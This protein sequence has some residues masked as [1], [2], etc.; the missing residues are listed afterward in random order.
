[1]VSHISTKPNDNSS[2]T[3]LVPVD[4]IMDKKI[5]SVHQ[6]TSQ[7]YEWLPWIYNIDPA[8]IPQE[9]QER[10]DFLK[11]QWMPLWQ[12]TAENYNTPLTNF[13]KSKDQSIRFVEAFVGAPFGLPLTTDNAK[14]YFPFTDALIL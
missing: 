3:V 13:F 14:E 5:M 9:E 4:R 1:M 2:T 10:L 12:K 11:L 8:T 7:V 6:N